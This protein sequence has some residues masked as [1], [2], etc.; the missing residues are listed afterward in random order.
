MNPVP[1]KDAKTIMKLIRTNGKI[2]GYQLSDG[3]VLSK[4]DGV[5]LAKQGGIR[6]VALRV[7]GG[8]YLHAHTGR[9]GATIW[10]TSKRG[11]R[12]LSYEKGACTFWNAGSLFCLFYRRFSELHDKFVRRGGKRRPLSNGTPARILASSVAT[13][14]PCK[15][16]LPHIFRVMRAG[17]V[18]SSFKS[19]ALHV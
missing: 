19:R 12:G 7:R 18:R 17:R 1:N 5:A 3:T 14:Q 15:L 10:V 6:G 11:L 13:V 2:S 9:Q 16:H 4:A 8:E